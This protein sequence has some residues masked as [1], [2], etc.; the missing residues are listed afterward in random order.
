M[1]HLSKVVWGHLSKVVWDILVRWYHYGDTLFKVVWDTLVRG[2]GYTLFKVVWDTL[3][4]GYGDTFL[5]WNG[6]HCNIYRDKR[7]LKSHNNL[8]FLNFKMI[9][10]YPK[11]AFLKFNK[12]DK[13]QTVARFEPATHRLQAYLSSD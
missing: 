7:F 6:T 10:V 4:R 1:G 3:V 9:N 13:K 8:F 12:R 2:Y 11:N 5:R